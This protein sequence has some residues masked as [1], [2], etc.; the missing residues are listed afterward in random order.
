MQSAALGAATFAT[1]GAFA[2]KTARQRRPKASGTA[3]GSAR[4]MTETE[5]RQSGLWVGAQP[6]EADGVYIGG[7]KDRKG[8]IHYLRDISNGHVLI[9]GP[10]RS[11]KGIS[12]ILPTLLSWRGSA[13]VNDEKGELWAQTAPWRTRHVGRVI[14]WEPGALTGSASW[15]PLDEVRIGTFYDVADAQNIALALIDIRG[16]GLDR[17]DHW[18]KAAFQILTGCVLHECYTA[19]TAGRSACLPDVAA[20]FADPNSTSKALFEAMRDNKHQN[21][22]PHLAVA[23]A[24]RAHLDRADKERSGVESTL[25]THLLLFYDQI[26]C[27]NTRTSDFKLDDLADGDKPAS[28]FIIN[29]AADQT[30]LRPL[31][32]LFLIMAAKHLMHPELTYKDGQPVSPHRH[33]TLILLDEFPALGKLDEFES[34]LARCASWGLKFVIACQDLSQLTGI[35]GQSQSIIANCHVRAF[36][37]TNDLSTAKLLSESTGTRTEATPHMTIMGRRFGF[38]SQVTKSI[39][40]TSRLLLTPG[41]ILTMTPAT[42]DAAGRITKGGEMLIFLM[43]QPPMRAVQL[44]YFADQEFKRRAEL[45]SSP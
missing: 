9:C 41:E 1:V 34:A 16:A 10:T 17:L 2:V 38:L 20:R 30:R 14:K 39:Q 27:S 18:Q 22:Q 21:G 29:R 26:V 8:A 42:K 5:A 23:A 37:P 19:H 40:E 43:G 45:P 24:G 6:P 32:R 44:L 28:I 7:W 4:F 36:F 33:K 35:Y 15:N 31:I 13:L 12:C 25:R 3:H 11:G